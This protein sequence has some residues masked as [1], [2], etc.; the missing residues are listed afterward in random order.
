MRRSGSTPSVP[1]TAYDKIAIQYNT[2]STSKK[3]YDKNDNNDSLKKDIDRNDDNI[4]SHDNN[5]LDCIT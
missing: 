5:I 4:T 2:S 1:W 3:C